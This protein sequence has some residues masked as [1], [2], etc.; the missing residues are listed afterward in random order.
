MEGTFY[1]NPLSTWGARGRSGGCR[2]P[3][4]QADRGGW[5]SGAY[6]AW[7]ELTTTDV[8]DL[9]AELLSRTRTLFILLLAIWTGS[10]L[11]VLPPELERG[12]QVILVLGLLLQASVWGS[13]VINHFL[14]R[15]RRRSSR[16]I[17]PGRPRSEPWAS[18]QGSR[19]GSSSC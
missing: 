17:L 10:K 6:A 14:D 11:L 12:V 3:R 7:P 13:A 1:G 5:R 15:Y 16:P 18:S 4:T 9:I 19:S 8:D 2:G